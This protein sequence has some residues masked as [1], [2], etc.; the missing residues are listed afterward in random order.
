MDK[1]IDTILYIDIGD[2]YKPIACLTENSFSET[3][4]TLDTTTR[5]NEGW[6]TSVLTNQSYNLSFSG[7]SLNTIYNGD[8]SKYSYD[9]LKLIK[10]NRSLINWKME[11]IKNG[12]IDYGK[13]YVIDLSANYPID[14]FINYQAEIQGY[15]KPTSENTD[16]LDNNVDNALQI[17]L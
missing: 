15:G 13:G 5:D 8:S 12:D 1:G 11:N 6:T 2:G 16:P 9:I 17:L 14:D 10:R 4:E 7:L 3:V